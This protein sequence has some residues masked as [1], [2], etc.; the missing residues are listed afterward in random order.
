MSLLHPQVWDT[1]GQERFRSMAPMYYRHTNAAFLIFDLTQYNT[2]TAIKNWVLELRRN[3]EEAMVL[4]L[5]GNKMDLVREKK[6][7]SDECRLYAQSIGASYHEI[8]VLHDEGV[9]QVFLKA[10]MGMMQL[11]S[12]DKDIITSL[13][14]YD[15]SPV[16][17]EMHVPLSEEVLV[18]TSIAH[19]IREKPFFCC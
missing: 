19:G 4:I 1:A 13:K 12:G 17:D 14:I 7:D 16:I 9:E 2:F 6:V 8:S 11:S 3:V 10:A 5:V 15:D 18:K